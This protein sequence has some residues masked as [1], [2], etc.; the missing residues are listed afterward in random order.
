MAKLK[1]VLLRMPQKVMRPSNLTTPASEVFRRAKQPDPRVRLAVDRLLYAQRL[2]EH[3]P[4]DL[5]HL[6]HR[7]QALCTGSWTEGLLANLQWLRMTEQD[8]QLPIDLTDLTALFD[9]W[10]SGSPEW[11]QRVKR[12]YIGDF[13]DK[14]KSRNRCIGWISNSLPSCRAARRFWGA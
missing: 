7:E 13:R 14:R 8:A 10:Q 2:W 1:V 9:F 4:E 3:G 5:Q 12:A 6:I 11:Q